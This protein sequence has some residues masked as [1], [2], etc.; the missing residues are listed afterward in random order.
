M[1]KEYLS[2]KS[3][4]RIRTEG[5]VSLAVVVVAALLV[6]VF[7]L[8]GRR[9]PASYWNGNGVVTYSGY[10]GYG[11]V[12]KE[13]FYNYDKFYEQY[14]GGTGKVD[15]AELTPYFQVS[16]DRA[17]GL[18]NGDKIHVA[19]RIDFDGLNRK[20]PQAKY[21]RTGTQT[22]TKTFK[23][24]GL[25]EVTVLDPSVILKDIYVTGEDDFLRYHFTSDTV[26]VGDYVLVQTDTSSFAL[27]DKHGNVV[28]PLF[29]VYRSDE[30]YPSTG[31]R[32][33]IVA[34]DNSRANAA[35]YG[36]L[37]QKMDK[38]LKVQAG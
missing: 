3:E 19:L 16:V 12:V 2:E 30:E 20:F 21:K 28:K 25:P 8:A 24:E 22:F 5:I 1:D 37:V 27:T 36:I 6:V 32:V 17:H 10:D 9:S 34:G 11:R 26:N 15:H 7:G 31:R 33:E 4:K 18:S 23:V 38:V 14:L 13:H 29:L 35:K